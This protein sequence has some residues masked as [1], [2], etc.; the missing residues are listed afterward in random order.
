VDRPWQVV[1]AAHFLGPF[2]EGTGDGGQ[3]GPQQRFGEVEALFVLAGGHQDRRPGL[4]R[5][6]QHAESVAEAGC[7]VQV[8]HRTLAGGLGVAVRH[9]HRGRLLQCQDVAQ[10][11]LAGQ[12]IHQRQFRGPGIAE[13]HVDALLLQQFEQRD[14]PWHHRHG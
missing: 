2:H 8:D 14:L 9:A 1:E 6:V 11:V 10:V 5:V 7:G 4:L 12:R 13:H 3:V